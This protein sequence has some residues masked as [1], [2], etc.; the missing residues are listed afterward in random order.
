MPDLC[1]RFQQAAKNIQ[2]CSKV[3]YFHVYFSFMAK[4]GQILLQMISKW[5]LVYTPHHKI[6]KKRKEQ[7]EDES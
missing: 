3:F 1:T 5:K 6:G 4:F 7:K 2:R